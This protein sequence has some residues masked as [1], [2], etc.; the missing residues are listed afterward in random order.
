MVLR[1]TVSIGS[2]KRNRN[3]NSRESEKKRPESADQV[4]GGKLWQL[5]CVAELGIADYPRTPPKHALQM[6]P[7]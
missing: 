7:P 3:V 2:K 5:Y 1:G 4:G 6:Q